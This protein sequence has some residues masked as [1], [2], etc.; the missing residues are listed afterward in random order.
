MN[1]NKMLN[2]YQE[3]VESFGQQKYFGIVHSL[4]TAEEGLES[5]FYVELKPRY[6]LNKDVQVAVLWKLQQIKDSC[7]SYPSK[8]GN[9]LEEALRNNF[10][11]I[12]DLWP[13]RILQPRDVS[14]IADIIFDCQNSINRNKKKKVWGSNHQVGYYVNSKRKGSTLPIDIINK[15]KSAK[16]G[17]VVCD[18]WNE[19]MV[20]L[21]F[22]NVYSL[23]YWYTGA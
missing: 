18:D 13:P 17:F 12:V 15:L 6:P 7:V 14:R 2:S 21:E 9:E 1:K 23:F 5:V 4:E 10:Q 3:I 20:V 11:Y 19:L 22:K 16:T 8:I